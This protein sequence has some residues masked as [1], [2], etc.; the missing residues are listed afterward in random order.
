MVRA[1]SAFPAGLSILFLTT[2]QVAAQPKPPRV[3]LTK[4]VMAD[5]YTSGG[6]PILTSTPTFIGFDGEPALVS[7]PADFDPKPSIPDAIRWRGTKPMACVGKRCRVLGRTIAAQFPGPPPEA[8]SS[9]ILDTP[10]EL[11]GS[12]G[13]VT[14]D[15]ALLVHDNTWVYSIAR[16]RKIP[17]VAPPGVTGVKA[18]IEI[19]PYGN[20]LLTFWGKTAAL[21]NAKGIIGATF[22]AGARV[23][24]SPSRLVVAGPLVT[25]IDPTSGKQLGSLEL[26]AA[27]DQ[28]RAV[29]LAADRFV[30]AWEVAGAWKVTW[31]KLSAKGVPTI[32]R[33]VAIPVC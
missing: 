7:R 32:E 25:I 27:V 31:I 26:D 20:V 3:C 10:E 6:A 23:V 12:F 19:E 4:N 5:I 14:D 21:Y 16:D 33:Q 15:L 17:L 18:P 1:A 9:S 29:R 30:V 13:T 22:P 2:A 28:R 24:L 11:P 8:T